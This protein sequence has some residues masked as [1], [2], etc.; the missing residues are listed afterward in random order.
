MVCDARR[1]ADN[2]PRTTNCGRDVTIWF[3]VVDDDVGHV[4]DL[5]GENAV[6]VQALALYRAAHLGIG[7]DVVDGVVRGSGRQS[8][9]VG[10]DVASGRGVGL[11]V[12]A[13]GASLEQNTFNFRLSFRRRDV[14]RFGINNRRGQAEAD[15]LTK[16]G[17]HFERTGQIVG[18]DE[19]V[20]R[21][22]ACAGTARRYSERLQGQADRAT[23][24]LWKRSLDCR[25]RKPASRKD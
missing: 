3:T 24:A 6:D 19:K 22:G 20:R 21:H 7:G 14:T 25:D 23:G 16:F 8:R 4:S 5:A 10:R 18:E 11:L 1:T 2:A 13:A 9:E 12:N 17:A 15:S